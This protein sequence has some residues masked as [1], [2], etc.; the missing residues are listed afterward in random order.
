MAYMTAQMVSAYFCM[1]LVNSLCDIIIRKIVFPSGSQASGSRTAIGDQSYLEIDNNLYGMN[2]FKGP[3]YHDSGPTQ[4]HKASTAPA[5]QV[6]T[7]E[8][9]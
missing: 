9:S 8:H 4:V 6:Q 2:T 3:H 1:F 7:Y 5:P